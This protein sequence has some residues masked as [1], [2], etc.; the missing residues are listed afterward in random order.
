MDVGLHP[1]SD[2]GR[3]LIEFLRAESIPFLV[4]RGPVP[5]VAGRKPIHLLEGEERRGLA[6][7]V[8]NVLV[9]GRRPV[10]S[11]GHEIADK[12]FQEIGPRYATRAGGYTRIL[13]TG[14]R[15]GDGAEMARI[16]LIES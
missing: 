2:E 15:K 11:L 7:G 9:D 6:G 10:V 4:F 3:A 5:G 14:H 16:E 1:D 8:G 13:K 12:L